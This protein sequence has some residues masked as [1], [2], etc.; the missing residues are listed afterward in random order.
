MLGNHPAPYWAKNSP[1]CNAAISSYKSQLNMPYWPDLTDCSTNIT[2][3]KVT[4]G[5]QITTCDVWLPRKSSFGFNLN[6]FQ[7][8]LPSSHI[9]EH[10]KRSCNIKLT[11]IVISLG[12]S[13]YPWLIHWVRILIMSHGLPICW[14][15][16]LFHS[17]G[18]WNIKNQSL[19]ITL[20]YLYWLA[21][22]ILAFSHMRKDS[23]LTEPTKT[24]EWPFGFSVRKGKVS[25]WDGSGPLCSKGNFQKLRTR[26]THFLQWS[27]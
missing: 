4:G 14:E 9:S 18:Q 8:W 11:K 6:K 15:E 13:K 22:S 7:V 1:A 3:G 5:P 16:S 12:E 25:L 20:R 27:V 26:C 17:E 19:S 23:N 2:E 21:H 24:K 10:P